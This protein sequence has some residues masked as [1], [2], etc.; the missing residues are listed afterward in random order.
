MGLILDLA[1][2]LNHLG[3]R[4]SAPVLLLRLITRE[5]GTA[6][7]SGDWKKPETIR[8]AINNRPELSVVSCLYRQLQKLWESTSEG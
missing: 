2:K 1:A 7:F 4:L 5:H 3:S 8:V 6:L